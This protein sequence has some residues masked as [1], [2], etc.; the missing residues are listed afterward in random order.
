MGSNPATTKEAFDIMA[1]SFGSIVLPN[2]QEHINL[3]LLYV[4]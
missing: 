4:L 1:H 3:A 2:Y